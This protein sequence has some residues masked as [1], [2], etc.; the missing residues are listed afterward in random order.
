MG[1]AV[2]AGEPEWGLEVLGDDVAGLEGGDEPVDLVLHVGLHQVLEVAHERLGAAVELLVEALDD[3]L[4]EH[5]GPA[6]LAVRA[7]QRDLPVGVAG[8]VPIDGV[9][10]L[11]LVAAADVEVL[12]RVGGGRG[13]VGG[14]EVD[15]LDGLAGGQDDAADVRAVVGLAAHGFSLLVATSSAFRDDRF[16]PLRPVA[17]TGALPLTCARR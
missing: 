4:L 9:D 12:G 2:S 10:E 3:V 13:D 6:P 15:D 5:A 8:L 11:A 14:T 7:A 16:T 17:G 1:T